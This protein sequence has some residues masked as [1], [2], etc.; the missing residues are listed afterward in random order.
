MQFRAVATA[1]ALLVLVTN[2]GVADA[3]D[4]A[5]VGHSDKKTDAGVRGVVTIG[6]I[7]PGAAANTAFIVQQDE[8][9]VATFTT[10]EA[11]RF[12]VNLPA[13]HYTASLKQR[14]PI[15]QFGPFGFDVED[16]QVA[17]VEW[18]CDNSTGFRPGPADR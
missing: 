17:V 12:T 3:N 1:G 6:P 9:V 10:D 13:G 18:H 7:H 2:A 15:G 5:P 11:G 8:R 16:G 4:S 14:P